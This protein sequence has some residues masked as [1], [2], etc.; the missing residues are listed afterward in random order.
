M[1]EEAVHDN[2][3]CLAVGNLVCNSLWNTCQLPGDP[4]LA[5]S[6]NRPYHKRMS[7]CTWAERLLEACLLLNQR[8]NLLA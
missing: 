1:A 4:W 6:T 7:T 5:L 8:D 2:D 3:V